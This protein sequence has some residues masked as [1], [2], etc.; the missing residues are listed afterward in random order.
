MNKTTDTQTGPVKGDGVV[1]T[2]SHRGVF[3]G[4]CSSVWDEGRTIVLEHC[5]SIPYWDS[6]RHGFLG[7]ATMGPG[8]KCRV[9]PKAPSTQ[10]LNVTSIT[11]CTP[12]AIAAWE[13]E[14]WSE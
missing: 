8:A 14:P 6:S 13:A 4:Y 7:L 1:V 2:T 12:E 10:L 9:S 5:R 3:F 11:I